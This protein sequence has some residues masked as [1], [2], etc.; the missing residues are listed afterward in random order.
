MKAELQ[1]CISPKFICFIFIQDLPRLLEEINLS[2]LP[3]DNRN[4]AKDQF[5]RIL[6]HDFEGQSCRLD[7]VCVSSPLIQWIM[8]PVL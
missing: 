3:F 8:T 5:I 4:K 7:V 1:S 2:Y 6:K